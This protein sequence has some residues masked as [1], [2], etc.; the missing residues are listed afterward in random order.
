MKIQQFRM[1]G[2]KTFETK[3]FETQRNRVKEEIYCKGRE[4]RKGF[5]KE[6]N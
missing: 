2:R 5:K 3:T 1:D 4:G 6:Q